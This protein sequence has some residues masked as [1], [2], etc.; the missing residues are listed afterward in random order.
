MQKAT[1]PKA[2]T[3]QANKR[4]SVINSSEN[5]QQQQLHYNLALIHHTIKSTMINRVAILAA[6]VASP[7]AFSPAIRCVNIYYV[8]TTRTGLWLSIPDRHVE[9]ATRGDRGAS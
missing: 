7:T 8:E 4:S 6:L 9:V 5:P 2:S 3:D 1:H